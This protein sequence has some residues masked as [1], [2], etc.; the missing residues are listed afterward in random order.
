M[1]CN[2][3]Y[4]GFRAVSESSL[5]PRGMLL[6]DRKE[7][8]IMN[9]HDK[10]LWLQLLNE[11]KKVVNP[12]EISE[13]IEAGGV[14]AAILTDQGHIYTGVCIDTACSLGMCAERNAIAH[15][16]TKGES[17]IT[18]LVC[19]GSDHQ[20]MFPCGSCREMM[21]QLGNENL[22][23]LTDPDTFESVTLKELIPNWWG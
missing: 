14:G 4:R 11:A 2:T 13:F 15:M 18:R 8:I 3:F 16:I 23:I 1:N 7:A 6:H 10:S 5:P 19:I 12:R 17:V 22:R 20:L 21:M 9:E